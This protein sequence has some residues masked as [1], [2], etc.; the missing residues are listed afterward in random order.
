MFTDSFKMDTNSE[1]E[2]VDLP[3]DRDKDDGEF[4]GGN[5]VCNE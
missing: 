2:W 1:D 3:D 5:G 4:K